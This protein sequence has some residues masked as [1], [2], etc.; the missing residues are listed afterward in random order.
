[1]RN[2]KELYEFEQKEILER[3]L[4]M[5]QINNN[6]L[7]NM[8][9]NTIMQESIMEMIPE[10]RKYYSFNLIEG[11][12]NPEKCKRPWLSIIRGICKANGIHIESK[13]IQI[14]GKITRI[15]KI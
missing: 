13:R 2:K 7:T 1:M 3:L 9:E 4:I 11:I 6:I 5:S 8:D 14:N 12:R 10:I 15:F